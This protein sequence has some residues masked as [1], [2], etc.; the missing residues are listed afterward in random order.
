MEV[1]TR[2]APSPTGFLH[3]GGIRTN[4]YAWLLARHHGG[5]FILRIED[6]DQ[7]RLVPG[8]IQAILED[9]K[10]LDI[11]ID[12]GPS[13]EELKQ[14][15]VSWEGAS[16]IGGPYGPYIQSLRLDLYRETAEELIKKGSAYRCDCTPEMLQRERE[17]QMARRETPGYSGFCRGRNV[18]A[19]KPHVVR[20]IVPARNA[21]VLDDG[22]RGKISW[23]SL[24]LRD[25]VILKSDGYP[26]YHL[27]VVVDDHYMKISHAIRGEE[28][29]ATAPLHLL[30][31]QALEW[32]P[33]VFCHLPV[34]LGADGKKL[35]KRHGA[36][37]IK[38][39]RDAGYLPKA[40]INFLALIGWSPGEG[41]TQEILSM[42]EMVKKFSL[43]RV[44][45]ASGI[46]EYT[47]LDW[48]NGVYI[49]NLDPLELATLL[50]PF[51][52]Q[53]GIQVNEERLLKITPYI[54]DR[55]RLLTEAAPMVQFLFVDEID[56]DIPAMIQEKKG[57]S[58]AKA[59]E[60]LEKVYS[61]LEGV[62]R[63][64]IPAVNEAIKLAV[65]ELG[66][67]QGAVFAATRIAVTGKMA[68]PPLAESLYALGKEDTLKRI[69]R[70]IR[71]LDN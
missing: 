7:E 52:T 57:I 29:I 40:L 44:N 32:E 51:L 8:V 62:E 67:P 5:K 31:Y 58:K 26:T 11:D 16:G 65:S 2:F 56:C 20:F 1:R 13:I 30:L 61:T 15:G 43:N 66:V 18:A 38:A 49:R 22:V 59:K 23:E 71:L 37:H 35:S 14:A 3:V 36:T 70:T 6:T 64:E 50:K 25:T 63:F 45:S 41:G 21:L 48:M 53:A 34:V 69:K 54:K 33:P 39:F 17:D 55:I 27:A 42:Q 4:F 46:F 24:S 9:L 12:E 19:D 47:K 60:I 10:W 28:W 68:T